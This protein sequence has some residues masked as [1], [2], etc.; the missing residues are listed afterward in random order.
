M[1]LDLCSK[2]HFFLNYGWGRG[3][4]L[5][6]TAETCDILKCLELLLYIGFNL[7]CLLVYFLGL[8]VK[9]YKIKS[10]LA[11]RGGTYVFL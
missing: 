5:L 6:F 3:G 8:Y 1:A 7:K 9:I 11:Q 10:G 2:L 4:P